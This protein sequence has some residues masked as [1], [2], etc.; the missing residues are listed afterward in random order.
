MSLKKVILWIALLVFIDQIIKI[1]INNYFLDTGFVIIPPV[2]EFR[3][4]F[5]AKGPY[6]TAH[7]LKLNIDLNIVCVFYAVVLC[8]IIILHNKIRKAKNNTVFLDFMF[9]LAIAAHVCALAGFMFWKKGCLDY[10]YLKPLFVF[11]LKDLYIDCF[12]CLFGFF[13]YRQRIRTLKNL[14]ELTKLHDKK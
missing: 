14:V 13:L 9:I 7:L 3:P 8:L 6:F 1:V 4:V 11:D 10:I 12:I 5:N 2:F